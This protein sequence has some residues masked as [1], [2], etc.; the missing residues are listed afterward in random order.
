MRPR[1]DRV[2][3]GAEELHRRRRR[4][5]PPRVAAHRLAAVLGVDPH[6]VG[7]LELG[8]EGAAVFAVLLDRPLE[9][10]RPFNAEGIGHRGA[11]PGAVQA[12]VS[13]VAHLRPQLGRLARRRSG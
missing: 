13:L 3:L 12:H 2:H 1:R 8:H 5:H 9:G 7:P 6:V 4:H 11:H 10:H